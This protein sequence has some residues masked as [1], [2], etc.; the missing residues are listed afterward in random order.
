[1]AELNKGL[2]LIPQYSDSQIYNSSS[3]HLPA[4]KSEKQKDTEQKC[5]SA[6]CILKETS[7]RG[8]QIASLA[9]NEYLD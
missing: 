7:L 1:M 5:H 4:Y 3:L 8:D 2:L 9:S 6:I